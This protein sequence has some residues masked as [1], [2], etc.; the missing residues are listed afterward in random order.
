MADSEG[1]A[2]I[3]G[4]A[5]LCVIGTGGPAEDVAVEITPGVGAVL[6][7]VGGFYHREQNAQVDHTP[8]SS[9]IRW[10]SSLD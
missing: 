7:D 1:K 5:G 6:V 9:R 2:R 4:P 3:R 10:M 8:S